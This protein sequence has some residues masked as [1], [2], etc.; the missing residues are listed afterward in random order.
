VYAYDCEKSQYLWANHGYNGIKKYLRQKATENAL[1]WEENEARKGTP[2]YEQLDRYERSDLESL[3][4]MLDDE[5]PQWKDVITLR[6]PLIFKT[7]PTPY[8]V[9]DELLPRHKQRPLDFK[10]LL[11]VARKPSITAAGFE[12][13][14]DD[15]RERRSDR[16]D[17][18]AFD[19]NVE[20]NLT[21]WRYVSILAM[22]EL[23]CPRCRKIFPEGMLICLACGLSLATVSDMRRACQIFRMEELAE[24]LGFELT[25]DMLGDDDVSGTT[26]GSKQI[27]SAAAVLKNHARSY[28]K[29]ARKV[30]MS[31]L[32]R[33]GTD[34]H[35]AFN[36]AVQDLTP[37]CMHW[38]TVLGNVV[39][40]NIRRTK[41]EIRTG[42][43][44]QYKARMCLI[45]YEAAPVKTLVVDDHVLFW[46]KNRF[47]RANQFAAAY[48][49]LPIQDR[50]EVLSEANTTFQSLALSKQDVYADILRYV[51]DILRPLT[52]AKDTEGGSHP[53]LQSNRTR[54]TPGPPVLGMVLIRGPL[55]ATVSRNG[56]II[57]T[58]GLSKSGKTGADAI[59]A[60]NTVI[61]V[62][63]AIAEAP[64]RGTSRLVDFYVF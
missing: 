63:L 12:I 28:M 47:Y 50:F 42:K 36:C 41:E 62:G 32:Q 34:A 29:Q 4:M 49:V 7:V 6:R 46:Y 53:C 44:R 3:K 52:E 30:G 13:A 21:R 20:G 2:Q 8:E 59:R 40:P 48:A 60:T 10:N 61:V 38:I 64:R 51:D 35:F 31:L 39:L 27:R 5:Y 24:K 17:Q 37:S 23:T 43:I 58:N 14:P 33:L 26:Q 16:F 1:I 57:T 55:M 22:P 19:P 18:E 45:A 54:T 11:C 25:L 56:T 15:A 9:V